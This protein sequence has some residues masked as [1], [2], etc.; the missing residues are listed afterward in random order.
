MTQG[1]IDLV[2]AELGD[3]PQSDLLL[4]QD[5]PYIPPVSIAARQP[6]K[7]AAIP[8]RLDSY[9][10]RDTGGLI[11][12]SIPIPTALSSRATAEC[13]VQR[14][15]LHV[16]IPSS[17]TSAQPRYS[18]KLHPLFSEVKPEACKCLLNEGTIKQLNTRL[19]PKTAPLAIHASSRAWQADVDMQQQPC[20]NSATHPQGANPLQAQQEEQPRQDS[21]PVT[22]H[23][24]QAAA[25]KGILAVSG[26]LR[27]EVVITLAKVHPNQTWHTLTGPNIVQ[28]PKKLAPVHPS[29]MAALRRALIQQR[30]QKQLSQQSQGKCTALIRDAVPSNTALTVP[31]MEAKAAVCGSSVAEHALQQD[32]VL[33]GHQH[34][35]A[36]HI[37]QV[38]NSLLG[39][40]HKST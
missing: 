39:C 19:T 18:L 37:A 8:Q 9:T 2:Q 30:Q 17:Q 32:L 28:P 1:A 36:K 35:S 26:K 21:P 3:F 38:T 11:C 4:L 33:P 7:Q 24:Q 14:Q 25:G 23:N 31:L 16:T 6:A 27:S 5:K 34:K 29:D 12:I 10:W 20:S 13:D 40:R 22:V 15:A